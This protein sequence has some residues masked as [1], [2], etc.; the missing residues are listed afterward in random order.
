MLRA[1]CLA[2]VAASAASALTA[3]PPAAALP[4][5]G[6]RATVDVELTTTHP[7]TATGLRYRSTIR[8]AADGQPP[9][10]RRLVVGLPAGARVDTGVP[11]RCTASDQELRMRGDGICPPDS[12]VGT[13][14][15]E[16]AVVGLGRQRFVVRAFND[17]GQQN[18]TVKQ[19]EMVSAVVRGVF[20][21]EGLD[22]RIPTCITGGQPPEGCPFDQAR[23]VQSELVVPPLVVAGRS[24][25]TTPET[26][27]PSRRWRSS[28]VMT[29]ADGVT[30]RLVTEQ[31]CSPKP[32]EARDCRSRRRVAFGALARAGL[33]SITVSVDGRRRRLDPRRPVLDLQGLPRGRYP[34]R[35]VATTKR[36]RRLEFTRHYR[37][38]G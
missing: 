38:C 24:Y 5:S 4:A 25:F 11:G 27:P 23:L 34:A 31:P 3:A 10:L 7:G 32:A 13:G 14:S 6:S 1:R 29:Y 15:A 36:G 12:L 22:A 9:A 17:D 21:D 33:R 8:P 19:G 35:I 18:Q 2:C 37:T 20:T 26:C 30:E 28:I 16:I